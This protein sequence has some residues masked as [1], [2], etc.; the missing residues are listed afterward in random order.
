MTELQYDFLCRYRALQ[1]PHPNNLSD[2]DRGAF[3]VC[4][5]SKY[6]EHVKPINGT[7]YFRISAIGEASMLEFENA[8]KEKADC[9]A[10][11][12]EEKTFQQILEKER[13]G[14]SSLRSWLQVIV[15]A[16]ACAFLGAL[17]QKLFGLN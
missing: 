16:L 6:I 8:A 17:F 15:S 1:C 5:E 12:K 11:Q 9:E 13:E 3:L 10:K 7:W 4:L 14:R 2:S